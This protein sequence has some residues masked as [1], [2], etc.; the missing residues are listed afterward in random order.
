VQLGGLQRSL[1]I[2]EDFPEMLTVEVE[3][4]AIILKLP[5]SCL[6]GPFLQEDPKITLIGQV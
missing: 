1:V 5:E 4:L 3:E 6:R 2:I